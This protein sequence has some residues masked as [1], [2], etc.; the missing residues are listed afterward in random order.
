MKFMKI[1]AV[2]AFVGA[3]ALS[4]SFATAR[5]QIRF[6]P[7]KC[8][9]VDPV[10]LKTASATGGQPFFLSPS[11]VAASG[12]IM[13][14]TVGGDDVLVLWA[15]DAGEREF[16]VPVDATIRR[17]TLSATF[18]GTGGLM[19]I[20]AP[21]GTPVAPADRIEE[22]P[23]NCGRIVTVAR[24][25]PATWRVKVAASNRFWL[26]VHA[27]SDVDIIS[28]KFVRVGGR[29]GHEGLMRIDGRP[30]ASRPAM[31]QIN[32]SASGAKTVEW[33][34]MSMQGRLL[35]RVALQNI[36]REE[37]AG[38]IDLP[39]DFFRLV[40]SGVDDSDRP[41]QRLF[42]TAFRGELVELSAD[43]SVDAVRA[44][45]ET[46][47]RIRLRNSGPR[48]RYRI[49]STH[50]AR[51]L[52]VVPAE[53]E[54]D[55]GAEALVTVWVQVPPDTAPGSEIDVMVTATGTDARETMNYLTRR[56]K[57]TNE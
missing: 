41:Y 1:G 42:A 48:T 8:G 53:V 17:L 38:P 39:P 6:G 16:Q 24:P 5:A 2:T 18:D 15:S 29:P 51:I 33:R 31:L 37:F 57:V 36:G 56:L 13:R 14:E 4:V 46:P 23:L 22:T 12:H 11:E 21:D 32:V 10:Y 50:V 34:L 55:E 25:E 28:A 47:L 52:R 26:V 54:V 49:V 30:M 35:Q 7:G 44:G 43:D 45:Q 19:T 40:M 9:P 3:L 27:R 20:L